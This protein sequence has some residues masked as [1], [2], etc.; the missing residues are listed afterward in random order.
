LIATASTLELV[1]V[2]LP[3]GLDT[4]GVSLALGLAGLPAGQ[5][6]RVALLFAGFE[7][8]M[9]LIGIALGA[10]LGR[11]LGS[12]ADLVAAG[13]VLGLGL[14]LLVA[15]DD[16]DD[17]KLLSMTRR[18]LVGA[19]ALGLSISLDELAIGFSAGLL[20]LPAL[21][22][23]LAVGAQAFLMT[24]VGLRIGA[25]AGAKTSEIAERLAGVALLALGAVLAV[26]QLG[27]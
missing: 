14:Y 20:R 7:T 24:Q 26:E 4:L 25:H 13:L 16:D 22:L 1:G 2:I 9:P 19:V 15:G 3:L 10:P 21:P 8:A 11:T 18:G 5:R 23:V 17:E 12:A 27:T 6:L